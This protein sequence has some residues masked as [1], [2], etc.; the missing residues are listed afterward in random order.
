MRD[1]ITICS[2]IHKRRL[3]CRGGMVMSIYQIGHITFK[4]EREWVQLMPPYFILRFTLKQEGPHGEWL[5]MNQSTIA[6]DQ[7]G[8]YDITFN[9]NMF[10][11]EFTKFI[12]E[13]YKKSISKF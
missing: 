5:E 10:E 1:I 3:Q 4:T 9:T 13:E 2:N 11:N 6:I 7:E 12:L 8:N